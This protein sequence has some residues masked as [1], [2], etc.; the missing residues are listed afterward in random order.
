MQIEYRH[1]NCMENR[2]LAHAKRKPLLFYL[3]L[4]LNGSTL[5]KER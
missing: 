4:F 1:M 2:L 5:S 3:L